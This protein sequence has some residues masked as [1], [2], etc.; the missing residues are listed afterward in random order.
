M[1]PDACLP[2][3]NL[4]SQLPALKLNCRPMTHFGII[5]PP[6]PGHLNPLAALGRELQWRG[7]R[8]TCLQIPDVELKVR[9]E[10]LNFYPLGQSTYQPGKLA[11]TLKQLS[12]LSG[13]EAL[14]YSVKFC[15]QLAAIICQD[16]PS[17]IEAAGIEA[18]LVDQLEPTGETIA[19]SLGIPFVSVC[20]GQAIHRQADVPPFFTSWSYQ[21]TWWA[22]L[23]NLA[24][25]YLL[26]RSCQPILQVINQYRQKWKLPA[27]QYY[28]SSCAA[29]L[30]RISQQPAAFDFPCTKPEYFHYTGPFRNSSPQTVSFPFERLTGQPTIYASLGSIQNTKYEVFHD[31]ASACLSLDVQLVIAHGGGMNVEAVQKLPGS[32]LVVEYAPQLEVLAKASLTITHGGLN[33]VLDS[34]SHGVPL[35]AIPITYEQPGTGARIR[36]T[37]TGEVV[38]L[39][40]LDIPK[41]R[42]AIQR[43]LTE[44]SYLK[45]A[46]RLKQAIAQAG[47]VK[48]AAD[49]IEQ[50]IGLHVKMEGTRL[51]E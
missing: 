22:R 46:L 19:E 39:S 43:V 14:R 4:D 17:A 25:Y 5:C 51:K 8:V 1:Q 24:A 31:I 13:L 44:D 45:N 37:G 2:L 35:V 32:P 27:Y 29:P 36:W 11:E 7:H 10:G 16:A 47:G 23:R 15:Q 12:K 42:T 38:P 3:E 26:D 18:L 33:T 9:S 40:H 20:C 49:I 30:A 41:L 28:Y 6:F 21:N 34:L 50:S 48:R